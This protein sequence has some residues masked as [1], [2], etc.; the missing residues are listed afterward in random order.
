MVIVYHYEAANRHSV[1]QVVEDVAGARKQVAIH[2]QHGDSVDPVQ[3]RQR[4]SEE[5]LDEMDRLV[6]ERAQPVVVKVLAHCLF[7]HGRHGVKFIASNLKEHQGKT[8]DIFIP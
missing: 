5:T 4:V 6:K 2:A 8:A 7:A 1:I 3:V